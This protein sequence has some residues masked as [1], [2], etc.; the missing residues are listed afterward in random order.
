MVKLLNGATDFVN[1]FLM[2]MQTELQ[3]KNN[4]MSTNNVILYIYRIN[5]GSIE[6]I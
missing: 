5:I 6:L 1:I 3:L 2:Q 4:H